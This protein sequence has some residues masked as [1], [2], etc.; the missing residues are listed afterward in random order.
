MPILLYCVVKRELQHNNFPA[1]VS[2]LPV[3]PV[4]SG[5]L[6]ALT[7]NSS[8]N[9]LK[10]NLKVSAVEFHGVVSEILKSMAVIPFRFPTIFQSEQELTQHL[11][12]HADQ[13]RLLLDKFSDAVQMEIRITSTVPK[14]KSA[15][16]ADYLK[17]RQGASHAVDQFLNQI[18]AALAS[19]TED[20]RS[21]SSKEGM[22]AFV[23]ITRDNIKAFEALLRRASVPAQLQV[24]VSG[25]W[26]V[27]EFIDQS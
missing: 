21:R 5:A 23:L 2:G 18:R 19:L 27:S 4:E 24:R 6:M 8:S 20:W 13:Y 26:P 25:P 14:T 1:G 16:G 15:S 7:S 3:V 22:R 11:Q 17:Q 9:R 10:Q 12:E